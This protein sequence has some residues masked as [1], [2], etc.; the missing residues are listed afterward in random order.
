MKCAILSKLSNETFC[1]GGLYCN[2]L[3]SKEECTCFSQSATLVP[4]KTS[5]FLSKKSANK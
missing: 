2:T 1:L 4:L 3:M 5:Q